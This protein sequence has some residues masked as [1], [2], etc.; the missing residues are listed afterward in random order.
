[1]SEIP[2]IVRNE[3]KIQDSLSLPG[4]GAFYA[5]YA[6][7]VMLN[8]RVCDRVQAQEVHEKL[9]AWLRANISDDV[10]DS[11]RIIYG[12]QCCSCLSSVFL[13]YFTTEKFDLR[14]K[15]YTHFKMSFASRVFYCCISVYDLFLV[16]LLV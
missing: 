4:P 15:L 10:A 6:G 7:T 1:M 3:I 2:T 8:V 11:V 16:H 13:T 9:R 5:F 14:S 12:G